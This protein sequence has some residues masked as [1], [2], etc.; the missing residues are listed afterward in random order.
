M[1]PVVD[2]RAAVA[3]LAFGGRTAA[4]LVVALSV[5]SAGCARALHDPSTLPELTTAGEVDVDRL[6]EQA[7]AAYRERTVDD[8]TQAIELWQQAAAGDA[9]ATDGLVGLIQGRIWLATHLEDREGRRQAAVDAVKA[10]Q[11]CRERS[12]AAID[13]RYWLALAVG[14][15]ARERRST[16]LDGVKLVIELLEGVVVE[17]PDFDNAGPHRVL[18][19][20]YLR[21]PGWPGGPGDVDLGLDHGQAAVAL[22][23]DHAPNQL[24]L[25]EA[26]IA[27]DEEDAGRQAYRRAAELARE[28]LD[29][30]EPDAGEWLADAEA[31]LER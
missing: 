25:G 24:A 1:P 27:V 15:Q 13:C 23:P 16:G 20:V 18:S 12:A 3:R 17:A 22:A 8:V 7:A 9:A 6:L 21:A 28:A 31:A 11:L 5:G 4:L 26:W 2:P 30:G 10:G 14:V 29:R 19:L